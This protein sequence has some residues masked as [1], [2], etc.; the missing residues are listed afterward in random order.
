MGSLFK[1]SLSEGLPKV[2][3]EM[4]IFFLNLPLKR[5]QMPDCSRKVQH[6]TG[7]V[8]SV[9]EVHKNTDRFASGFSGILIMF[10]VCASFLI[11]RTSPMGLRRT[12]ANSVS[13]MIIFQRFYPQTFLVKCTISPLFN[14]QCRQYH[15]LLCSHCPIDA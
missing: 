7:N 3:V 15:K 1:F 12:F 2:G 8:I 4:L 10:L 9:M 14:Y 5:Y 11:L 6:F 13:F